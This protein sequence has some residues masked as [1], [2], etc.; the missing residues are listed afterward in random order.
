MIACTLKV[1][2]V[3]LLESLL[4]RMQIINGKYEANANAELGFFLYFSETDSLFY[5][6]QA[7]QL[8]SACIEK[9][10]VS[11]TEGYDLFLTQLKDGL[12][13]TSHETAANHKVAKVRK[14]Y[15]CFSA[16]RNIT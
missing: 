1:W 11:S 14:H 6:Y 2:V 10:D 16:R 12:K 9:V 3:R 7:Q 8:L 13:N 5:M 4:I 15:K